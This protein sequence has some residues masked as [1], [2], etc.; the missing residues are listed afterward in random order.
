VNGPPLLERE[1]SPAG[2]GWLR[3]NGHDVLTSLEAGK[4]NQRIA[5]DEVLAFATSLGRALLTLNRRHFGR[6][7]RS[8]ALHAGIVCC[9]ADTDFSRQARRIDDEVRKH[10]SLAGQLLNVYKGG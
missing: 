9:T 8:G 7:H 3:A 2:G 6:L 1:L 10:S 5:D 4:A